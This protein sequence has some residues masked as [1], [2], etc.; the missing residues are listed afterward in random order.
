[1]SDLG[2]KKVKKEKREEK[3]KKQEN[4]RTTSAAFN[5]LGSTAERED[6]RADQKQRVALP[7]AMPT[8]PKLKKKKKPF[9][10]FAS[11]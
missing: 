6:E 9:N 4:H 10:G 5:F 1:M 8:A 3:K 11:S 7:L 2:Q